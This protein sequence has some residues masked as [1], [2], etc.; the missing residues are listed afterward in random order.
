[1]WRR[2][3]DLTPVRIGSGRIRPVFPASA[4]VQTRVA[5][6]SPDYSPPYRNELNLLAPID[7]AHPLVSA[8]PR[9]VSLASVPDTAKS[10]SAQESDGALGFAEFG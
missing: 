8:E 2:C 10:A 4:P 9:A 3:D 5:R 1:M 7:F 6:R